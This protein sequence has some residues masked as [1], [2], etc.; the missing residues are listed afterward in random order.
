MDITSHNKQLADFYL[1][2]FSSWRVASW[3]ISFASQNDPKFL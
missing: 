3:L 2:Q 1:K